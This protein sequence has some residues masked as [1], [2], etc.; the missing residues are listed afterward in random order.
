MI[1]TGQVTVSEASRSSMRKRFPCS[2]NCML[3]YM[4]SM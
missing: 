2:I 1:L 4:G 3:A